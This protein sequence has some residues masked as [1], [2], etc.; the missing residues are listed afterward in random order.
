MNGRML[1]ANF[2]GKKK[3]GV[4]AILLAFLVMPLVASQFYVALVTE[5]M[6]IALFALSLNL[7]LGYGGMVSFGHGVF[8]GIGAYSFALLLK[9]AGWPYLMAIAAA[10]VISGICA[11]FIG[12]FCVR[13]T[14]LYFAMLT[15]AFTQIV[16]TILREWY[17]LTGGDDGLVNLP[18]PEFFMS[19][20]NFYYIVLTIVIIST[21]LIR[22]IISSP[23]GKALQALRDNPIRVESIGLTVK[24]YRLAAFIIAGFFAGL[25][26]G[27]FGGL[28]HT[29]SPA[30][31]NWIQSAEVLMM[32]LVG[33]IGN[34][35]GPIVGA[36]LL[37]FLDKE[38][39]RYTEYWSLVMGALLLFFVLFFRG[40]IMGFATKEF[41]KFLPST[42]KRA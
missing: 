20:Y 31:A 12:W 15:L 40:G 16:Y 28:N 37:L 34:F 17:T 27:L 11:L 7:M 13:L 23:F 2:F 4:S 33:G 30:Y 24:H 3:I 10:P 41:A 5:M 6:I 9:N 32:C 1:L 38:I 22:L 21:A 29:A 14:H 36:G 8:L 39:G 25:A 26:G 19:S 42:E 18:I 35:S